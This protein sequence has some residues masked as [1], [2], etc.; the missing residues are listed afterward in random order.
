M[1]KERDLHG[2]LTVR[3]IEIYACALEAVSAGYDDYLSLI[4]DRQPGEATDFIDIIGYERLCELHP[5]QLKGLAE[6]FS[7]TL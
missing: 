3:G 5:L 4:R 7:L 1:V 6:G 2:M